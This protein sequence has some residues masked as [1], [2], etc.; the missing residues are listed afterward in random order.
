[1][2]QVSKD[3][4][5]NTSTTL[6]TAPSNAVLVIS[7]LS[8]KN[9]YAGVNTVE[10][11]LDNGGAAVAASNMIETIELEQDEARFVGQVFGK[12]LAQGGKLYIVPTQNVN[13]FLAGRTVTQTQDAEDV[14]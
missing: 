4:Q 3:G 9:A 1:M 13:W 2:A 5:V 6:F 10:V 8:L 11:H 14:G 7:S 12:Q